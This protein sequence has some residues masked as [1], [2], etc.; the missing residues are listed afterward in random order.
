MYHKSKNSHHGGTSIVE[1]DG[2]LGELGL[3]IKGVPAEVKGSVTEVTNELTLASYVLH[4]SKL[5]G[6]YEGYN[7]EKSSLWDGS[8]GGPAVR[9]GVEGGS[10]GVD[11]SWKVDSVTGHDLSEEGKLGDTSVLD[12]YVT[13]TVETFLV[14]IVKESKRIEESKWWLGSELRL[15]GAE[16]GGG[17]GNLGRCEGGGGGGKGGGND[18]LHV[19]FLDLLNLRFVSTNVAVS[20]CSPGHDQNGKS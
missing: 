2:T 17:L 13:K 16:G 11:V 15:E 6:S 18:K 20:S 5:K 14:G 4:D 3:L 10:G 7:L 19:D 8:Y 1:L 12:L 9:D